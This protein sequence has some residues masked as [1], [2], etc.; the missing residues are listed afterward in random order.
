MKNNIKKITMAMLLSLS[1][2]QINAYA[3]DTSQQSIQSSTG[4]DSASQLEAKKQAV[5]AQRDKLWKEYLAEKKQQQAMQANISAASDTGSSNVASIVGGNNVNLN[6]DRY[7][8]NDQSEESGQPTS[9][10]YLCIFVNHLSGAIVSSKENYSPFSDGLGSTSLIFALDSKTNNAYVNDG[11]GKA[12]YRVKPN[13]LERDIQLGNK[14]EDG[15][16]V[17]SWVFDTLNK[18]VLFS[19]VRTDK[20][21]GNAVKAMAGDIYY[22][23][24]SND[25][26]S[27]QIPTQKASS[28]NVQ[29]NERSTPATTSALA[30]TESVSS[31][32]ESSETSDNNK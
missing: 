18:K 30:K 7:S 23:A 6:D 9:G 31:I 10:R 17:D 26:G 27:V 32:S 28:E 2:F 25:C 24:L 29:S 16:V 20:I 3:D 22:N 15:D 5:L 8:G 14:G 19:Q 4:Q 13:M 11:T 21:N 12:L 1:A